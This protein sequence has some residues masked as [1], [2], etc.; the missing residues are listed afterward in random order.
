MGNQIE[1]C[2]LSKFN[3]FILVFW[4]YL[5]GLG[6]TLNNHEQGYAIGFDCFDFNRNE[7]FYD[8]H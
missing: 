4:S 6:A 7:F 3:Y 5:F 8:C 1:P 2:E